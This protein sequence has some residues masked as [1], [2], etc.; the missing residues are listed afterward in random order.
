MHLYTHP[1]CLLHNAGPGHPESPSRLHAVLDALAEER[2][3]H[4]TRMQAPRATRAQLE[5]AHDRALVERIHALA[6]AEG[7]VRIDADTAMCPDSVEAA[8][9]AAGAVCA[10]VDAMIDGDATRAFCAVRPPGHHATHDTAMGFCLFNNIAVGAAHALSRGIER[11]AIVDFDVHHGNGTQDI[12]CAQP[13]VLYAS[14][15]QSPLYPGTGMRNETGM[16][17]IINA[18]LSPRS[19]SMEFRAAFENIVLAA[20][21]VFKPQLLMI[22]AGFDA[23]RLDP[24]ADLNLDANDYAWATRQLGEV[25]GEFCGGRIV[26]SLEGGYSLAALRVSTAAHVAALL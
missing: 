9:R 4:I 1:A 14:T 3:A 7:L 10:A 23:H 19:G 16:G 17:N 8:L 24:L 25:A 5:G 12:F 22:S 6:P 13:Q 15:H 26:S 20:L 18:P 2:F 21:R 11:V